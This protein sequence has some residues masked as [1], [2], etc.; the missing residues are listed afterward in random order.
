MTVA[1][2][3]N[4][5]ALATWMAGDFSN[6]QQ[7]FDQPSN[8]AHIHVL[9]RPL[10]WDFFGG[11][12]FYSEQVY[13]YDLWTPYRQGIH[14]LVDK[15]DHIYI[16]NY[17]LQDPMLYAGAARELSILE[18]IQPAAITRRI[19]CSMVFTRE[20]EMFR[21]GVEPGNNCLIENN[22]TMTYLVSQVEIT[23]TS[24]QSIDMGLDLEKH[25]QIWGSR[26]GPL[27]FQKKEQYPLPYES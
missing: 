18:T 10:P 8:F 5:L 19:N 13:D 25:E 22:G 1:I 17:A 12:G 23:A 4:L 27:C 2:G 20:G 3:E 11:V 24:W 9:W 16:E 15:G 21:G 26:F 14:L 7:S 6:Y